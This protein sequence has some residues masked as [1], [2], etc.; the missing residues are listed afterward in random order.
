[1]RLQFFTPSLTLS[2]PERE[3]V[4]K[5]VS[6]ALR[7]FAKRIIDLKITLDDVNGP[8]GGNDKRCKLQAAVKA[9]KLHVAEGNHVDPVAAAGAAAER[10]VR[11][12]AEDSQKIVETKRNA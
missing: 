10:L 3:S 1:M 5:R 9:G 7:R 8:K 2:E 4:E 6:V 12:L 11:Q